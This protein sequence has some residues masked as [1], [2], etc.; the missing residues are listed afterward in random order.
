MHGESFQGE[1]MAAYTK[2]QKYG[3]SRE[4]DPGQYQA[5]IVWA[6]VKVNKNICYF[7]SVLFEVFGC[8]EDTTQNGTKI[9]TN[10]DAEGQRG[11]EFTKLKKCLW[12]DEDIERFKCKEDLEKIA[13]RMLRR[14]VEIVVKRNKKS[15]ELDVMEILP[16]FE[17]FELAD[18]LD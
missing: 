12:P 15:K 8:K 17:Y 16:H 13:V 9:F 3:N 4:P 7:F 2:H 5:R 10:I 18:A 11:W 14:D 6:R 1:I